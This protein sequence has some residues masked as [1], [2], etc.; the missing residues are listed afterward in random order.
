MLRKPSGGGGGG[1]GGGEATLPFS[2]LPFFSMGVS[3]EK[4]EFAPG[5]VNSLF[6]QQTTWNA[7]VQ[8]QKQRDSH[9]NVS[10]WE[11]KWRQNVGFIHRSLNF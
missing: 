6:L 11:K 1:G 8:R 10:L 5:G 7:F 2:C 9:K 3:F 4:K